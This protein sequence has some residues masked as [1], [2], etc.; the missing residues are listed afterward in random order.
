LHRALRTFQTS[1]MALKKN[2]PTWNGSIAAP[3]RLPVRQQ[4][5]HERDE[6]RRGYEIGQHDFAARD[7]G[8][9]LRTV[10]AAAGYSSRPA[11]TMVANE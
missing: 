8:L 4:H 9:T 7:H 10:R 2:P 11:E 3:S 1:P 6:Q 5:V